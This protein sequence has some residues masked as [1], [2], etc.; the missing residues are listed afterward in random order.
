MQRENWVAV[1]S[2]IATYDDAVLQAAQRM[3]LHLLSDDSYDYDTA[4]LQAALNDDRD[5]VGS[6][7][8]RP[9]WAQTEFAMAL[10]QYDDEDHWDAA[11]TLTH[12]MLT[13]SYSWEVSF[14]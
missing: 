10:Q 3:A 4:T 14:V 1:I 8:M 2:N 9:C 13:R 11:R 5:N 7:Y 6:D 12:A